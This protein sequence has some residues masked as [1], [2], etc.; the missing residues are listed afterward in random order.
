MPTEHGLGGSYETEQAPRPLPAS[1]AH[2]WDSGD[3]SPDAQ[4][5]AIPS[6]LLRCLIDWPQVEPAAFSVRLSQ[7]P[8][9]SPR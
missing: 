7:A 1:I 3:I 2:R 9:W 6:S 4:E 5:A 8:D